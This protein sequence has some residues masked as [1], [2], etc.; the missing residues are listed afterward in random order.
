MAP[1]PE[2]PRRRLGRRKLLATCGV[3]GAVVVVLIALL[4]VLLQEKSFDVTAVNVSYTG[5]G[6]GGVCTLAPT[7]VLACEPNDYNVCLEGLGPCPSDLA[8]GQSAEAAFNIE[9]VNSSECG[10]VYEVTQVTTP[11]STYQISNVTNLGV[12]PP[13]LLGHT[14]A[15]DDPHY[16]TMAL[17]VIVDYTVRNVPAA[18]GPLDL[19]VTVMLE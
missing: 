8:A 5:S 10:N 2:P 14:P 13:F 6:A 17:Q 16:C 19:V 18:S 15:P 1:P 11:S 12:G 7:Y 9:L 3:V 4:V